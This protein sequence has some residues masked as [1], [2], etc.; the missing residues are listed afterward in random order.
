MLLHRLTA[1]CRPDPEFRSNRIHSVYF[2]T[3]D[4]QAMAEVENGDFYKTKLRVRWYEDREEQRT[5]AYLECKRKFGPRRTK[6]RVQLKNEHGF[7]VDNPL[8]HPTWAHCPG[9]LL[10][11]SV[12]IPNGLLQPTLH[13]SYRRHRFVDPVTG[14]RLSID[15]DIRL[16]RVHPRL[17]RVAPFVRQAAPWVVLECKGALRRLPR[18]LRFVTEL[19]AQRRSFSKYGLWRECIRAA[20]GR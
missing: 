15:D 20:L 18:H 16:P 10:K 19:G 17:G 13:I 11:S 2:D 1:I 12:P 5:E 6:H 3:P 7:S 4:M 14:L 9:L 8:D